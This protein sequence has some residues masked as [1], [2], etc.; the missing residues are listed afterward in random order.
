MIVKFMKCIV[1]LNNRRFIIDDIMHPSV[2]SVIKK[3]F[4]GKDARLRPCNY[5]TCQTFSLMHITLPGL[6]ANHSFAQVT[7][8][9]K[10]K[11][12]KNPHQGFFA[13]YIFSYYYTLKK[14]A[15]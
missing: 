5:V 11:K 1:S 12:Q 10:A 8:R 4:I 9:K 3:T 7:E 2:L 14:G 13:F 6:H 15:L